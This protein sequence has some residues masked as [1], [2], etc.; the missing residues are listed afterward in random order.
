MTATTK[1]IWYFVV[2][3]CL[4]LLL[5]DAAAKVIEE[6][7]RVKSNI[8]VFRI[9]GKKLSEESTWQSKNETKPF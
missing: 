5:K 8:N 9:K 1:Q 4:A 2:V 7:E 6:L 3:V